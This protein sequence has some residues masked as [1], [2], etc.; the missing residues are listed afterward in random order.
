MK[1]LI[2][3][4]HAKSSWSDPGLDDIDR[5]LAERGRRAAA[6]M[7]RHLATS[8]LRP[9]V[10]LCSTARRAVETLERMLPGIEGGP[11]P[12]FEDRLY[13]ASHGALLARLRAIPDPGTPAML[14]GH[15]PGME[16]LAARLIGSGDRLAI[17]R[18]GRKYPTGALAVITF[19]IDRWQEIAEGRGHLA[20]YVRPKELR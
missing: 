18:I 4:R 19:E 12:I 16:E 2:L 17:Q 1:T 10:I 15:N 8:G 14:V 5:P 9:A 7:A 13:L 3:L 20:S 11:A 6:A